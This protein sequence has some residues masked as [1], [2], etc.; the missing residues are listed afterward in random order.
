MFQTL[1][2]FKGPVNLLTNFPAKGFCISLSSIRNKSIN[3]LASSVFVIVSY[4]Q[5]NNIAHSIYITRGK[6]NSSVKLFDDVRVYIW[7]RKPSFG[8]KDTSAFIP[9]VCELFGHLSI[10]SKFFFYFV[11]PITVLQ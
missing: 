4:L 6:S 7:A 11:S 1:E 3:D 9:A 2:D 10:R 8:V 5:N